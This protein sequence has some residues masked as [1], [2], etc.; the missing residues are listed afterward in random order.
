MRSRSRFF[1]LFLTGFVVSACSSTQGSPERDAAQNSGDPAPAVSSRDPEKPL[2]RIAFGSC[3]RQSHEQGIWDAI[4]AEHP[5]LFLFLGDNI[6]GDTEDMK[7]MREK[8]GELGAKPGYQKLRS[9]SLVLA[10]WDD[11][12]YGK[13]DGGAEFEFKAEAQRELLTFFQEPEDSPRWKQEGVYGEWSFGPKGKRVQVIL[14]PHE[15]VHHCGGEREPFR[16]L[17]RG[18]RRGQDDPRGCPME[19]V[20]G[21]VA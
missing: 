12:D 20:G 13:N 15:A 17:R 16:A 4:N 5:E 18:R 9:N 1:L 11:H 21:D 6:Y 8:Y 2:T 3:A 10:T 14:L 7:V 19:V